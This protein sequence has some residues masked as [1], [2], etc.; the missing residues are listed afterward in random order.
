[1]ARAHDYLPRGDFP[2]LEFAKNF[3]GY[4]KTKYTSWSVPNPAPY[5]EN[6]LDE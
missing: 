1:M 3:F 5:I 6:P 2:L 4:A